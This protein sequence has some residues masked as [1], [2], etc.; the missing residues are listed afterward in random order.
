MLSAAG[1]ETT[2]AKTPPKAPV[3]IGGAENELP[4]FLIRDGGQGIGV[5]PPP[6][7][8]EPVMQVMRRAL[9]PLMASRR[10]V[11]GLA[12][13][14]IAAASIYIAAGYIAAIEPPRPVEAQRP[15]NDV[16]EA[17]RLVALVEQRLQYAAGLSRAEAVDAT[18][19]AR[20]VAAEARAVVEEPDPVEWIVLRNLPAG[21]TL[22]SGAP[23]GPGTWALAA[24]NTGALAGR[25]GEGFETAVTADAELISQAGLPVAQLKLQLVKPQA[26]AEG[27]AEMDKADAP[28]QIAAPK[29][30]KRKRF[31]RAHRSAGKVAAHEAAGSH[32]RVRQ[33]H[34]AYQARAVVSQPYR[35]AQPAQGQQAGEE[36]PSGPISKFF[37]WIKGDGKSDSKKEEPVVADEPADDHIRRG[38]GI[39][40]QE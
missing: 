21:A 37:A 11:A 28:Q 14:P 2:P 3:T 23:A 40:P 12:A 15:R 13:A 9:A 39:A 34:D 22:T 4:K 24:S 7:P 35:A 32:R 10:A 16:A 30:L 38:L 25:L 27:D 29:P 1:P 20:A 6:L 8:R 36:Q 5:V 26:V 19:A 18:E 17:V 33:S 31:N